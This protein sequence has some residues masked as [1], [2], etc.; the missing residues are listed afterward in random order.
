MDI[1]PANLDRFFTQLEV[2]YGL[3]L[4][5]ADPWSAKLCTTTQATTETVL[6]GW[7]GMFD[8]PRV[9]NGARVVREPAPQTYGVTLLPWEL[10]ERIDQFKLMNDQH[11]IYG[12]MAMRIGQSTGKL[13]DYA[14]RDMLQGTGDMVGPYGIGADGL[15]SFNS[16][17]PVDF[18][19]PGKGTYPNDFGIVGVSVNGVTVGGT[20]SINS[21]V[22]LWQDMVAVPNESGEAIG[23]VPDTLLCSA[24]L[25]FPATL[26][27]KAS[28]FSP[29][30][31]GTLGSGS[32]AN[33]PF[34]GNMESPL[35]GSSDVVWTADLSKVPL[36][37][38]MM[39]T[40]GPMKPIG[41]AVRQAPVF[42]V[43]NSPQDPSVFDTHSYLFGM[44][45]YAVPY[46]GLPWQIRR[47]GV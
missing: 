47:S 11:G 39:E 28:F 15:S 2:L 16:A 26:I 19:D 43:R 9:W 10:T 35:R 23:A 27:T 18:W 41:W 12:N 31:L 30:Q 42:V 22:T 17:H 5:N 3:A 44:W 46:W 29:P 37:F 14:V 24:Q 1:T 4:H 36:G 6:H 40:K 34:V 7:L 45:A 25:Y 13:Q 20:L 32:G 8:K 33:A 38:Y 21:Y